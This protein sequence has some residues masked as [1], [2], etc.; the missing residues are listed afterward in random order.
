M[1]FAVVHDVIDALCQ[2]PGSGSVAVVCVPCPSSLCLFL[3]S[4]QAFTGRNGNVYFSPVEKV[5]RGGP[6][7]AAVQVRYILLSSGRGA[8]RVPTSRRGVE[9]APQ[10]RPGKAARQTRELPRNLIEV[11]THSNEVI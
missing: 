1:K 10:E 4:F 5:I 9:Q 8:V 6:G 3:F 2:N 11:K 7:E